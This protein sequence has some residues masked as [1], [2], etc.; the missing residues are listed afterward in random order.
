[1][2]MHLHAVQGAPGVVWCAS[3]TGPGHS[4]LWNLCSRC[5]PPAC[6]GWLACSTGCSSGPTSSWCHDDVCPHHPLHRSLGV[7]LAS[8]SSLGVPLSLPSPSSS[9]PW[10]LA[11]DNIYRI[12]AAAGIGSTC[13]LGA[14]P[15]PDLR[16]SARAVPTYAQIPPGCTPRLQWGSI[17]AWSSTAVITGFVRGH[18]APVTTNNRRAHQDTHHRCTRMCKRSNLPPVSRSTV[19]PPQSSNYEL[20]RSGCDTRPL[21]RDMS[22]ATGV[23]KSVLTRC[24][25]HL[26][27]YPLTRRPHESTRIKTS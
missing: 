16:E 20:G 22:F 2:P 6:W 9:S 18:R 5:R 13:G 4:V 27:P 11:G 21:R 25:Q 19:Q 23:D 12:R 17:V 1:M 24:M 8:W 14:S 26:P 15:T 7:M 10:V 3:S